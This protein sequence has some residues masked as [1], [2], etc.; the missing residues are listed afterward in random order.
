M[1]SSLLLMISL[2]YFDLNDRTTNSGKGR[3]ARRSYFLLYQSINVTIQ[4]ANHMPCTQFARLPELPSNGR[5]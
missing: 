3:P 2:N 5:W 4:V 1:K